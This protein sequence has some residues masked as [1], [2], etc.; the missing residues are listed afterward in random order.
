MSFAA[1]AWGLAAFSSLRQEMTPTIA[2]QISAHVPTRQPGSVPAGT[3]GLPRRRRLWL[4]VFLAVIGM[5]GRGMAQLPSPVVSPTVA[6]TSGKLHRKESWEEGHQPIVLPRKGPRETSMPDCTGNL[7]PVTNPT[8]VGP[9][10]TSFAA[11]LIFWLPEG[12]HFESG[13]AGDSNYEQLLQR[14]FQDVGGSSFIDILTQYVGSNGTPAN[15]VSIGGM[16]VDTTPYPRAGTQSAPLLDSDLQDEILNVINAQSWP[17]GLTAMY[18][19]Y[20]GDAIESCMDASRTSCT[21]P[22]RQS[23]GYCAYHNDFGVTDEMHQQFSVIYA[24]LPAVLS[25]APDGACGIASPNGDA[26]ADSE[27]NVT[28]HEHFEGISDPLGDAWMDAEGCEIADKCEMKVNT[29]A[30][31]VTL[32][33]NPYYVQEEWSNDAG[34]CTLTGPPPPT[35]TPSAVCP[36][37]CDDNGVVTVAELVTGINIALGSQPLGD[38][39][40]MDCNGT[41]PVTIDCVV[42]AIGAALDGCSAAP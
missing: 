9:V 41:G 12:V 32:N 38:C 23:V 1:S 28:S 33:G 22:T 25:V 7:E 13:S 8:P 42:A 15:A 36:G 18:F 11:F 30:A 20:T 16:I 5:A 27:I 24:N 6:R 35:A 14:Y 39:P 34:G 37:D 3:A 29:T 17:V 40:A 21:F 2:T 31:D 4:A 26:A 10:M 19:I